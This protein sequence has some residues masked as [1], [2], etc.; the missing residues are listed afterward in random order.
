MSLHPYIPPPPLALAITP[1]PPYKQQKS[2]KPKDTGGEKKADNDHDHDKLKASPKAKIDDADKKADGDD[3]VKPDAKQKKEGQDEGPAEQHEKTLVDRQPG[4]AQGQTP[5]PQP[6]PPAD[7]PETPLTPVSMIPGP[8]TPDPDVQLANAKGEAEADAK[9]VAH[10]SD[11]Q[12][13]DKIKTK[14]EKDNDK[15]DAEADAE[16]EVEPEPE[17]LRLIGPAPHT[18]IRTRLDMNPLKPYPPIDTDPRGAYHLYAK[19]C[20]A[21]WIL[22]D[23]TKDGWMAEEWKGRE[24]RDALARLRGL[25]VKKAGGG[26]HAKGAGDVSGWGLGREVP[27]TAGEVLVQLWNDLVEAPYNEVSPQASTCSSSMIHATNR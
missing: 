4:R 5:Q 9:P 22:I 3:G 21:E 17:P 8:P 1:A 18:P 25:D 16:K 20:G 19:G 27:K 10:T 12:K 15:A 7:V 13:G 11:A 24:E 26:V 6:L 23:V 14:D 2:D